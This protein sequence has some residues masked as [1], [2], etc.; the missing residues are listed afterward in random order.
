[1]INELYIHTYQLAARCENIHK[2]SV[3]LNKSEK[4]RWFFN[5]FWVSTGHQSN[6][7]RTRFLWGLFVSFI[8]YHLACGCGR[9]KYCQGV[10][11]LDQFTWGLAQ[12]N[13][14]CAGGKICVRII[15]FCELLENVTRVLSTLRVRVMFFCCLLIFWDFWYL[16]F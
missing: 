5:M 7:G 1:M 13:W 10:H 4:N 3:F 11:V 9:K 12:I 2:S 6:W 8:L 14:D 15:F 16:H